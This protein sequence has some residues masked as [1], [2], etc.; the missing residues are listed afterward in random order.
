MPTPRVRV[1]AS[2]A[3]ALL[4]AAC[5]RAYTGPPSPHFD[6]SVFSNPGHTRKSSVSG[7]LWLR[8]DARDRPRVVVPLGNRAL[9]QGAMPASAVS[10]HDWGEAVPLRD[11]VRVHV[12]PMLH[13]S[14]RSPFD[15]Q[16]TL[17]AS[18]V[19]ESGDTR[20]L[21]V[22]DSG[23]GDGQ[24]FRALGE[25]HGGF[26]LAILPIGAYEPESFMADSHMG[27]AE[28]V[29]AMADLRARRALAH[30]FGSF[31]LGFEAHDAP[32]RGLRAALEAGG[33]APAQFA[34]L[35]PGQAIQLAGR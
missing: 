11:G 27:P 26:D 24:V 31:Q 12:E 23:Y 9:V 13:G 5:G 8:L 14:G 22:G 17:W 16:H 33:M 4:L 1:L 21:F 7:Y 28:A 3:L 30:H 15:Q 18:Y 20:V 6:G 10:E 25:R 2:V 34:A 29:K 19:I 32:E 35:L